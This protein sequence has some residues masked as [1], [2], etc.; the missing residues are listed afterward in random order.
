MSRLGGHVFGDA[1]AAEYREPARVTRPGGMS[2]PCPGNTD[3][4]NDTHRFLDA[5][6]SQWALFAEPGDGMKRTYWKAR[7]RPGTPGLPL[8]RTER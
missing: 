1:P 6:G 4:D 7:W 3:Q 8:R 5:Q 2:I